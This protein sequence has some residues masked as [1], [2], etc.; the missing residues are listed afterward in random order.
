MRVL[1]TAVQ[2][3]NKQHRLV[4]GCLPGLTQ[5]RLL[6]GMPYPAL[7]TQRP[8]GP[9]GML[10]HFPLMSTN[11]HGSSHPVSQSASQNCTVHA[12][13][14]TCPCGKHCGQM[15]LRHK[16]LRVHADSNAQAGLAH[17]QSYRNQ[18][19]PEDHKTLSPQKNHSH[20]TL[21]DKHK[22][23]DRNWMKPPQVRQDRLSTSHGFSTACT[24]GAELQHQPWVQPVTDPEGRTHHPCP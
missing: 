6:Q 5:Q 2:H 19:A 22:Q 20:L 8:C 16:A 4:C 15:L 7:H 10:R 1:H 13:D 18:A 12:N 17:S 11:M 21:G 3:R 24:V 9:S 23:L 14:V